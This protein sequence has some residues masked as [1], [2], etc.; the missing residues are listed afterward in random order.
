MTD[1]RLSPEELAL[2]RKNGFVVSQT[3][4]LISPH[5]DPHEIGRPPLEA[6]TLVDYYYGIWADD[7]PVLITTD[8]V[9]DAWHQTFQTMLEDIEEL[10][11]YPA[12]REM[13]IGN[14]KS[15]RNG[16]TYI[17]QEST[18]PMLTDLSDIREAWA[19]ADSPGTENI[20]QASVI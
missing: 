20:R 2:F 13:L 19:E 1:F 17:D 16:D 10:I 9:L 14:R 5:P 7:M 12:L 11:L 4:R 18:L 3:N 15:I 6:T 8:S